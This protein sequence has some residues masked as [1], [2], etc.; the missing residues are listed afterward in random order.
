MLL[1]LQV[2][3]KLKFGPDGG[4]RLIKDRS[5]ACQRRSEGI[6]SCEDH[7]CQTFMA[8]YLINVR[9]ISVWVTGS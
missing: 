6:T 7:E 5:K 1:V 8:V 4:G 2:S 3:V 9:D